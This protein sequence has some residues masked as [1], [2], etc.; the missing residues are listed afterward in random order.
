ML[1][2]ARNQYVLNTGNGDGSYTGDPVAPLGWFRGT[3]PRYQHGSGWYTM[4]VSLPEGYRRTGFYRSSQPTN[5]R[6]IIEL[7]NLASRGNAEVEMRLRLEMVD[8]IKS[9]EQVMN[10]RVEPTSIMQA[11]TMDGNLWRPNGGRFLSYTNDIE[12]DIFQIEYSV[13]EGYLPFRLTRFSHSDNHRPG[14][15]Y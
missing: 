2:S 10:N 8:T 14:D 3:A 5:E 11:S 12:G 4:G 9:M 1:N 15:M 6:A 7:A 13:S